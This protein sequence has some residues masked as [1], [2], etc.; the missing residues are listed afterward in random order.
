[1]GTY[2]TAH[3]VR[4]IVE[5][6]A[7]LAALEVPPEIVVL[8]SADASEA[9]EAVER[10]LEVMRRGKGKIDLVIG[11]R[12]GKLPVATRLGRSVAVSLIHALYG[13][14][15]ADI[16]GIRALRY[17]ALVALALS[18]EGPGALVEMLIKAAKL[19]LNVEEVELA[20][21][22]VENRRGRARAIRGAADVSYRAIYNILR[23]ATVR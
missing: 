11:A 10:V 3:R 8:V 2:R 12:A 13:K 21:V 17:P 15:F 23:H 18:D 22:P 16:G 9:G 4:S 5:G 1:M 20:V 19:G 7:K 14:R 6:V